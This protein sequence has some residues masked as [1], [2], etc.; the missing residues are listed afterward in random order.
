M[1]KEKTKV[2]TSQKSF[3]G[4]GSQTLCSAETSDSRKYVCVRRLVLSRNVCDNVATP[5]YPISALYGLLREAKNKRQIQTFSCKSGRGR[6]QEVPNAVICLG[7]FCY[8]GKL[9][10]EE[11]WSQPNDRWTNYQGS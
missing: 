4:S 8:F 3:P 6:L 7:N 2:I 1:A 9:V 11:R 5:D 10:A